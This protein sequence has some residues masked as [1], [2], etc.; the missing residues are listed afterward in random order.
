MLPPSP[1]HREKFKNRLRLHSTVAPLHP[2]LPSNRSHDPLGR[3][4]NSSILYQ[5]SHVSKKKKKRKNK[6][7]R[8]DQIRQRTP[9]PHR[10]LSPASPPRQIHHERGDPSLPQKVSVSVSVSVKAYRLRKA[11]EEESK[12]EKKSRKAN[13]VL[14]KAPYPGP[15]AIPPVQ[16]AQS[17]SSQ[18]CQRCCH[19]HNSGPGVGELRWSWLCGM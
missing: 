3:R 15:P 17:P 11:G 10:P 8:N 7:T 13:L 14:P 12:R 4:T 19:G 5:S 18:P 2:A 9:R 1:T 16:G 6:K